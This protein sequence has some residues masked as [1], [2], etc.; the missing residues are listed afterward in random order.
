MVRKVLMTVLNMEI[1]SNFEPQRKQSIYMIYN[2]ARLY[3]P[4]GQRTS[5]AGLT[6]WTKQEAT[7]Y[8]SPAIELESTYDV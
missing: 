4:L 7:I 5:S 2:L 8:V 1:S 6:I 3:L